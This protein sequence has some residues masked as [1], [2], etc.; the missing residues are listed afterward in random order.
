[1]VFIYKFMCLYAY[2]CVFVCNLG[3]HL[4]L[5][6]RDSS[7]LGPGFGVVVGII[8]A[9]LLVLLIVIDVSCYFVNG[10]GALATICSHVCGHH[11]TS[12]E[13]TMEEGDRYLSIALVTVITSVI[14]CF[15]TQLIPG[16][17]S[18]T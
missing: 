8:I 4:E 17:P 15:N 16:L 18:R 12:K 2:F 6:E 13:K 14:F 11:P 5:T 1:M 7:S 9:V 3:E 10:C